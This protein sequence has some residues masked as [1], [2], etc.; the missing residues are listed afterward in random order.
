MA[1][2]FNIVLLCVFDAAAV[3]GVVFVPIGVAISGLAGKLLID[4]WL[5][6]TEPRTARKRLLGVWGPCVAKYA[7][8]SLLFH[9]AV[10]PKVEKP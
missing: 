10:V 1:A 4:H 7:F 8:V 9:F 2:G 6:R 5:P 3:G